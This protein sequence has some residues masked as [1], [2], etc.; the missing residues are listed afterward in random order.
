MLLLKIVP[1]GR[2]RKA[3]LGRVMCSKEKCTVMA[4]KNNS[5]ADTEEGSGAYDIGD[6][7][8]LLK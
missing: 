5:D 7:N 1:Y 8:L 3:P 6:E 2:N 4:T